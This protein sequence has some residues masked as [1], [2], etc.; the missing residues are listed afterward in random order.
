MSEATLKVELRESTGNQVAKALRAKGRLPGVFYAHGES[1]FGLS[2]DAKELQKLLQMEINILDLTLPDGKSTK[3][4]LKEV[5]KD[6]VTD[7]PIHVDI[8]GIKMTE[9]IKITI[10]VVFVGSPV[11][12]REGGILEHSLREVEVEGLPLD[13]PEH[14]EVDISEMNIGSTITLEDMP[15]D[16]FKYITDSHH[17]VAQVVMPKAAI[18]E[19]TEA[20]E[21]ELEGEEGEEV[22]ETTEE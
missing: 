20:E 4:I 15:S 21:E 1:S 3:C 2:V 18:A 13:I 10:P 17:P 6:P 11:G 8:M 12:V 16:K 5:Q 19:E 22:E 14:L 9:K 7:E